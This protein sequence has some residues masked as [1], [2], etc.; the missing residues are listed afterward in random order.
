MAGNSQSIWYFQQIGNEV[1][2]HAATGY[3]LNVATFQS[4]SFE[5]G[6]A[7]NVLHA[8]ADWVP[9][10]WRTLAEAGSDVTDGA[11]MNDI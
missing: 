8:S 9:G 7:Y 6:V 10:K 4:V 5:G 1:I 2:A 3:N 11:R